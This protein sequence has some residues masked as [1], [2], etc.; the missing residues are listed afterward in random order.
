MMIKISFLQRFMGWTKNI[1]ES[2]ETWPYKIKIVTLCRQLLIL[3]NCCCCAK[4]YIYKWRL[5]NFCPFMLSIIQGKW[6][7]YFWQAIKK[8]DDNNLEKS[9][10]S[11]FGV[12]NL[13]KSNFE[14]NINSRGLNIT[15]ICSLIIFLSTVGKILFGMAREGTMNEVKLHSLFLP[16]PYQINPPNSHILSLSP[17]S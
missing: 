8:L 7:N 10:Y 11:T 4:S 2:N 17:T 16:L 15:G 1:Q 5:W 14:D 9:S 12:N 13:K 6:Q 3:L